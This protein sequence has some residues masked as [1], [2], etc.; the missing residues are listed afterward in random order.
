MKVPTKITLEGDKNYAQKFIGAAQSQL[1][2]LETEM[3]FQGLK[4]GV[5]KT[6]LDSRTTVE[7][8]VCFDLREVKIYSKIVKGV[9][10]EKEEKELRGR[11]FV[12]VRKSD[13]S[14]CGGPEQYCGINE[15]IRYYWIKFVKKDGDIKIY[16][17]SVEKSDYGMCYSMT[18][19]L[20][21]HQEHIVTKTFMLTRSDEEDAVSDRW[22]AALH[23]LARDREGI[24]Q[25]MFI[26]L[27]YPLPYSEPEYPCP[28]YCGCV[29]DCSNCFGFS[30]RCPP[31]RF[32]VNIAEKMLV[33]FSSAEMEGICGEIIDIND[34]SNV[35]TYPFNFYASQGDGRDFQSLFCCTGK[36]PGSLP[37]NPEIPED[38]IIDIFSL[39]RNEIQVVLPWHRRPI[40]ITKDL[41]T[42]SVT[43]EQVNSCTHCFMSENGFV[44]KSA[45][46]LNQDIKSGDFT[47]GREMEADNID[48][49]YSGFSLCA[50]E[51]NH[52]KEVKAWSSQNINRTLD[53]CHSK[54]EINIFGE[55]FV[56]ESWQRQN[57]VGEY[58]GEWIDYCQWSLTSNACFRDQQ[59]AEKNRFVT[60]DIWQKNVPSGGEATWV[61][62]NVAEIT[63]RKIRQYSEAEAKQWGEGVGGPAEEDFEEMC[64]TTGKWLDLYTVGKCF[65]GY[66]MPGGDWIAAGSSSV[67][68]YGGY[69]HWDKILTGVDTY[70][71]TTVSEFIIDGEILF[72]SDVVTRTY[73]LD[74]RSSD[75]SE[76]LLVAGRASEKIG[77]DMQG[78]PVYKPTFWDIRYKCQDSGYI[79][80]TQLI[81][82][83]LDC[84]KSEL[85]EI[86]LI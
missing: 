22:I 50:S 58:K 79:D 38:S 27:L 32:Y 80:V 57:G 60:D 20:P 11:F 30:H 65:F 72:N 82:D 49:P 31:D 37:S 63:K 5:R 6:R 39:T 45:C 41:N 69:W 51:N 26:P 74:D 8:S 15:D 36:L 17:R 25:L 53:D 56:S 43:V 3:E 77:K 52:A 9:K 67:S 55:T 47:D 16:K 84:E 64:F 76:G 7:S 68:F 35:K 44:F 1:R 2:I 73:Y 81:L 28:S 59:K 40:K 62:S 21:I 19:V 70:S 29:S 13:T 75:K 54:Y 34:T 24:R 85:I 46:T 12:A 10:K 18:T 86:G 78:F 61:G 23:L 42:S 71:E 48:C 4:Q 14:V 66:P 83:A 33:W